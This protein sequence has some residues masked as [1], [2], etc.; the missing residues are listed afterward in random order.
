MNP[1]PELGGFYRIKYLPFEANFI[2]TRPVGELSDVGI[3]T[4]INNDH[5]QMLLETGEVRSYSIGSST[6]QL[7]A[8]L[9]GK[10]FRELLKTSY[11]TV[12]SKGNDSSLGSDPEI[13]VI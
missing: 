13:F 5:F 9:I 4:A 10:R 6:V 3:V 7:Q 11:R 12:L 1:V 2:P 8:K